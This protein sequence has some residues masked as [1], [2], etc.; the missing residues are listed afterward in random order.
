[1]VESENLQIYSWVFHNCGCFIIVTPLYTAKYI[2]HLLIILKID[3]P[4]TTIVLIPRKKYWRTKGRRT[5]TFSHF[6][7]PNRKIWVKSVLDRHNLSRI[8]QESEC[9]W[10]NLSERSNE[11]LKI[12]VGQRNPSKIWVKSIKDNSLAPVS[13]RWTI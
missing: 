12:H 7:P 8:G 13:S 1:M 10:V 4:K 3:P 6:S 11:P 2:S 5:Q 9:V